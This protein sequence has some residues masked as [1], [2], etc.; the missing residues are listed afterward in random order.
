[1]DSKNYKMKIEGPHTPDATKPLY[2]VR[3]H[4]QG[5]FKTDQKTSKSG[6]LNCLFDVDGI[7]T[8]KVVMTRGG[9]SLFA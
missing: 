4:S 2:V 6:V 8:R 9:L 3:Y 7:R 1:M 5:P